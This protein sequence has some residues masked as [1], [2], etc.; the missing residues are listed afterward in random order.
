M[1]KTAPGTRTRE[2]LRTENEPTP[3]AEQVGGFLV[4]GV[5][6]GRLILH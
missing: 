5:I 3:D 2:A 4:Y 1:L 6:P